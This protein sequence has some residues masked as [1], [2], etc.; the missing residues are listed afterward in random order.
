MYKILHTFAHFHNFIIF[1]D[2]F[3]TLIVSFFVDPGLA[4]SVVF[5]PV[6]IVP[7]GFVSVLGISL[8]VSFLSAMTDS[9]ILM[10]S[11]VPCVNVVLFGDVYGAV[12]A[13]GG[14]V[15]LPTFLELQI[16]SLTEVHNRKIMH[17]SVSNLKKRPKQ[18]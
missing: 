17:S 8:L 15:N 10:R 2:T 9:V 16:R 1:T 18:N 6:I 4:A 12:V 7:V 14:H 5:S 3:S 11:S 13:G